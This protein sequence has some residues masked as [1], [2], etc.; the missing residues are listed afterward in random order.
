MVQEKPFWPAEPARKRDGQEIIPEARILSY[1]GNEDENP[2]RQKIGL[3]S[4]LVLRGEDPLLPDPL[5]DLSSAV[6]WI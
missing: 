3:D 4:T 1:L 2:L 6:F 5:R